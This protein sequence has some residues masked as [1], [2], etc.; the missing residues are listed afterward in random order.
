MTLE[1]IKEKIKNDP[2][3]DFLRIDPHLGNN[4]CLLYLSGSYA[5]GTNVED[6]DIDLRGVALNSKEE[7][8]LGQDFEVISNNYLD[9]KIYSFKKMIKMLCSN[10]PS[11]IEIF[12]LK[13]EHILYANSIGRDLLTRKDMFLTKRVGSA[14]K[15]Y[16]QASLKLLESEKCLNDKTKMAK[17]MAHPLRLYYMVNEILTHGTVTTYR[18]NEREDLMDVKNG[19]YLTEDNLPSDDYYKWIVNMDRLFLHLKK[20]NTLPDKL[21]M[22][23]IDNYVMSVH[24]KIVK[25]EVNWIL[26]KCITATF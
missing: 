12:G 17:Y 21:D 7:I 2:E 22:S 20:N 3:Y 15:G 5:Y 24:E 6:S 11:V 4:V 26:S 16:I 8:L 1:E 19:K 13:P 14:F 10:N 25:D 23:V 9:V 18:A